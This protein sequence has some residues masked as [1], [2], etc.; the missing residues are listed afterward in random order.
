MLQEING[1]STSRRCAGRRLQRS[2]SG[3]HRPRAAAGSTP[4]SIPR[5]AATARANATRVGPVR[6]RLGIR[7]AGGS[8]HPLQPRLGATRRHAVER[9][10][11]AG[12][13]GS[14]A[15][16]VDRSRHAGLH[17]ATSRRTTCRRPAPTAT[18]R[19]RGDAPFIMHPDGLGWIWVP[20]GLKDG[21][22]PAHYEPLES[23]V[24]QPSVS[25]SRSIR[26]RIGKQ[27][28]DN[29]YARSPGDPRYPARADDL[30][31]DRA[32]HRR[33]DVAH[34]VASR[35]AAAGALL[36][37]LT[38]ARRRDRRRERRRGYASSTPRGAIEARALVTPRM[39]PLTIHGRVVHQV[40][41]PYHFGGR[42]L[43][44]RRRRQRPGRDLRRAERADHGSQGR[45]RLHDVTARRPMTRR[46]RLPHR[47]DALHRLQSL[48]GRVQGVERRPRRRLR[49][50]R[51]S[52][53]TTPAASA[54]RP[55]GT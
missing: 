50:H 18:R 17:E 15:T 39:R 41:L 22:L 27:R 24:A 51:A 1:R 44:T 14:S 10:Q 5:R 47:L 9:T 53:T 23:P 6:P 30:P 34:A 28:P 7:L 3:R 25:R 20:S 26:P 43:V 35:R 36:R 29:P 8:T 12:L 40:G 32:S 11:E 52:R 48:R 55:G 38:R 33:R 31:A 13:V 46:H 4:A 19:S 54:T 45:C 49:V 16:R 42:G 37:D 2:G 21:P